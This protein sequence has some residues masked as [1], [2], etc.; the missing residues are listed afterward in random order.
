MDDHIQELLDDYR[1]PYMGNAGD[2]EDDEF[3][4]A[5]DKSRTAQHIFETAFGNT[6][7]FFH[8]TN[9]HHPDLDLETMKDESEGAYDRILQQLQQLRLTLRWPEEMVNGRWEQ[10]ADTVDDVKELL[11]PFSERGLWVFVNITR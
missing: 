9:E 8:G 2:L 10:K 6:E 3:K 4:A 5:E 7:I 11:K 1:R